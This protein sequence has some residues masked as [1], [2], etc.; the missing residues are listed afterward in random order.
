MTIS[1]KVDRSDVMRLNKLVKDAE[2]LAVKESGEMIRQTM[3]FAAQSAANATRPRKGINKSGNQRGGKLRKKDKYRKLERMPESMG[4]WYV[5]KDS[6]R[7]RPF[8]LDKRLTKG[9]L[10][11]RGLKRVL[12]GIRKINR[13]SGGKWTWI[14]YAG[15]KRNEND[16][17]FQI[18]FAGLAKEG[19]Y[20][21]LKKIGDRK[22]NPTLRRNRKARGIHKVNT[23]FLSMEVVNRVSYVSK[24]SPAA[25]RYGLNR[26]KNKMV[27][28]YQ[29]RIDKKIQ[30][31]LDR[32]TS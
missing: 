17:R 5:K 28:L 22:N 21:S 30:K 3:I 4:F 27:K 7:P 29:P 13:G 20:R 6:V 9:E 15:S 32:K 23:T 12:K 8:K 25:A 2:R 14:P 1:V 10:R 31:Q 24:S 16:K 26:A 18:P 19:W 11:S